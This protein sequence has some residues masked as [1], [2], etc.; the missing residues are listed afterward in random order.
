MR[1]Q[2]LPS[3]RYYWRSSVF[4]TYQDGKWLS[5]ADTNLTVRNSKYHVDPIAA[6]QSRQQVQQRFILETNTARLIY[7]VPQ[8]ESVNLPVSV[9]LRRQLPDWTNVYL[10][11]PLRALRQGDSYITTSLISTASVEELRGAG[12]LYP[13]WIWDTQLYVPPGVTGRTFELA[14]KIIT[15]SGAVTPYD[16]AKVI[17]RWLRNNIVYDEQIEAPP[18]TQDP[19]DWVL[20]DLKRGYCNYY[21]SAMVMMLRTQNVPARM[22]AGFSQGDW[23][24]SEYVVRER[25]AHT[26]VEVYFPNYGW[27][28]FEPT[29]ARAALDRPETSAEQEESLNSLTASPTV[30]PTITATSTTQPTQLAQL[31]SDEMTSTPTFMPSPTMTPL[32]TPPVPPPL[33]DSQRT[34]PSWMIAILFTIGASLLLFALS[35]IVLALLWWRWEWYGFG[36]LSPVKRAYGCLERYVTKLLGIPL[37]DHQTPEEHYQQ[38]IRRLPQQIGASASTIVQLYIEERYGE[39]V[40]DAQTSI[41]HARIVTRAWKRAREILL[42]TWAEQSVPWIRMIRKR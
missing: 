39:P 1:V 4:D 15:D 12:E 3:H 32:G 7:T 19:I 26:W 31:G 10:M 9:H 27:I 22:S 29:V 28:E 24:G 23:N 17:E 38:I 5:Q 25:D 16:K 6:D 18:P 37:E 11:R 30:T 34:L 14:Q 21:A 41:R 20:F 40:R 8:P 42:M 13:Q 35:V 2:V 36:N 33:P